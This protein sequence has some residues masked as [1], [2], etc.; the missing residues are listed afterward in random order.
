MDEVNKN[1][2][3][4]ISIY[5]TKFILHF[6]RCKF[7]IE[8]DK[9]FAASI[10][11]EYCFYNDIANINAYLLDYI[12]FYV[13]RGYKFYNIHQVKIITNSDRCKMTYGN[14]INPPMHSIER[15][16]NVIIARKPQLMNLF[17]RDKNHPLIKKYSHIQLINY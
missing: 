12:D 4:Y 14:Y 11:T 10:K 16:L 15:R 1:L 17:I 5:N 8:L 7:V 6:I 2:N 9:N 13:S 3:F